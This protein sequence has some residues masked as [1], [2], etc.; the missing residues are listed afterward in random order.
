MHAEET[1]DEDAPAD[2][3]ER[4]LKSEDVLYLKSIILYIVFVCLVLEQIL[5]GRLEFFNV[6]AAELVQ[7]RDLLSVASGSLLKRGRIL[8][9]TTKVQLTR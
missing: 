1:A 9:L 5:V 8:H 4:V 6:L 2:R 7:L 3:L